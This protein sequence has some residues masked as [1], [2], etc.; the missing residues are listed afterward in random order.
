VLNRFIGLGWVIVW[1]IP[2][3]NAV[4]LGSI[5]GIAWVVAGIAGRRATGVRIAIFAMAWP[6]VLSPLLLFSQLHG[7]AA[8]A[9]SAGVATQLTRLIDRQA[10]R[11]NRL[12]LLSAPSLV[13]LTVL[14][15]I[16]VH[17]GRWLNER[18]ALSELSAAPAGAPNVVLV[19]LDT[20]RSMSL[21]V[22]D[23]ALETTPGLEGIAAEGVTF[24]RAIATASWTLPSHGSLLTGRLPRDLDGGWTRRL[25]GTHP[26]LAGELG[27]VGY[28]TAG[29]VANYLY[30]GRESGIAR[31]F[32]HYD[33]YQIT[34]QQILRSS[35]IVRR[36]FKHGWVRDRLGFYDHLGRRPGRSVSDRFLDWLETSGPEA[37]PFFAFLNYFDAH[38]PYLPPSP[39]AE[40]FGVPVGR[41]PLIVY[42]ASEKD[43]PIEQ[44]EAELAAYEAGIAALDAELDRLIG[45]L[46]ALGVLDNTVLIVTSDHGEE[47]NEHGRLGHGET[48]YMPTV[49]VPLVMRFPDRIPAGGSVD[50]AV[51][52]ADIPATILD[53]AGIREHGLPGA[54]LIDAVGVRA[55]GYPAITEVDRAQAVVAG[56]YHLL[57]DVDDVPVRLYDIEA[58]PL[59]QH[60]LLPDSTLAPAVA[61][62]RSL[63]ET[64]AGAANAPCIGE[65]RRPSSTRPS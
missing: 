8:V 39:H 18:L 4:A 41:D 44:L 9:L 30:T 65:L 36:L 25:Q 43:F 26:T 62:L 3:A 33:D 51:S 34:V 45:Q 37:G 60:N 64:P 5:A 56:G 61:C 11:A 52:I 54:S 14:G 16:G 46:R 63:I 47:F 2:L 32:A 13:L 49:H 6:A 53:L 12:V 24:E 27:R 31:D 15:A 57:L 19:I 23:P 22:Y 17:G 35:A 20:V 28:R 1:M 59:E 50:H 38:A 40:R 21:G 42:Q 10:D 29:F 55:A 48:P 7:L 58:D